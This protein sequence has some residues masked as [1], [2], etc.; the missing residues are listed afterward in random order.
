MRY[1][2]APDKFK[3]TLSA[4]E[5]CQIL[6]QAVRAHDHGAQIDLAPIAD[7]GEGTAELVASQLGAE[8]R[9]IAT[10]DALERSISA[11]FFVH[12][13]KGYI[14]MSSESVLWPIPQPERDHVHS[15]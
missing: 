9:S 5:V 11:E 7:G 1:L 14:D 12:Q 3:G 8:R 6:A 4:S 13:N 15:N 10:V 2:I